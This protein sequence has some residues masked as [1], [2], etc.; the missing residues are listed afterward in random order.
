MDL[1]DKLFRRMSRG[2]RPVPTTPRSRRVTT[3]TS[4]WIA[5]ASHLYDPVSIGLSDW[6]VEQRVDDPRTGLGYT[7]YKRING[8]KTD[9]MVAMQGTRGPS[10]QDWISNLNF[11]DR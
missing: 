5:H 1:I 8:S 4:T 10:A 3:W 11:R 7:I 6:K 2:L 9:Y